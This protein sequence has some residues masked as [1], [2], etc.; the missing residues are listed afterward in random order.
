MSLRILHVED[1]PAD[2]DLTRRHL[3]RQAPDIELT[4]AATLAEARTCLQE[5][6]SFNAALV[7]LRLPD[8]SG[9]ELLNWIR[10]QSLPMAVVM[11]TGSGDQHAAVAALQ[12]GA[13]DYLTKDATSLERL[14]ATLRDAC[15]R[16]QESRIRRSHTLR[17]LYAEHNTADIDLTRRHLARF[18]PHIQLTVVPSATQVL[19]LLPE[20]ATAPA[21][22]DALLLDYRLPGL[23][24]LEVV[25]TLRAER[26]LD[27][28]VVIVSGQGSEEIAAKAIHLGVDDYIAKH[29]GYLHELPATLEKALRQV[30][31]A[32]E[33][34]RLQA[35]SARLAHVL[36][37]SPVIFYVL[38]LDQGFATPV[39]VSSNIQRLLDY[40]EEQALQ[41]EWW[42][43]HLHPDDRNAA[44]ARAGELSLTGQIAHNYR[45]LDGQG[46]TRWIRDE[47]RLTDRGEV[48]GAWRDISEVKLAEQLRETRIAMLDG[49]ASDRP[50]SAILEE[51]ANRLEGIHPD[52]LVSIQV[53]DSR[54][55]SL[56]TAAAPGLPAFFNDALEGLTPE[57]GL[58]ACGTAAATGEPVIVE[59]IRSHP[60][61][62]SF[63]DLAERADLRACWSIPFKD[64]S[65]AVLGIFNIHYRQP[66]TP[67]QE[68]LDLIGE[69]AR[70]AGL[71]VERSRAD[72]ILRQA[73]AV[74]ESAGE[75]VM[76]TDLQW[77]IVS[78]NSAF[79][80]ITGYSEAEVL[81]RNPSLL[82]SGRQDQSF[83]QA[84][85]NSIKETGVWKGELWDR[86]KNGELF[87]QLLT[88]STVYDSNGQPSNY[89][90]V[91]T[92]LSQIKNSEA[93]LEHLA[94]FDPLTKLPNRLLLQ[95]GLTHALLA[96]ERHQQRLAVLYIDLDRFKNINDSLGHPAGDELLEALAQRLLEQL[97]S[98]D[99]LGRLGGD[100]FLLILENLQRPEDAASIARELIESLDQ[101]FRLPSGHE[102]Y[103]GASIGISLFP[104]DG[105][106]C[107][108]LIQHADVAVYQ[109][110]EAG[111]NT[112]AFYTPAL[113]QIANERLDLEARLRVA[114][115]QREFLLHYQPQID[116]QTGGLVGCEALVRW[117]NPQQGLIAPS[118][119]IPL[120]E[121]TGLIVPLGEWVLRQACTQAKAWIDAGMSH[122]SIAVNLSAR[123]LQQP[124]IVARVAAI[125]AETGL[126][127]AALKL[128]LTESMIMGRGEEAVALLQRLK[129]LGL[130][131]SIDDFG[132]G[133]SSLA[134]LKRFPI[135][136]LK[137]DQGFVRDIPNDS[138]DNE[139]ATA[140]IG[141]AHG[142]RLSVMAEGVETEAQ[143][144]FLAKHGCNTYQGYLFSRPLPADEFTRLL[145]GNGK[146]PDKPAHPN[147]GN[148]KEKST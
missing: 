72:A 46:K 59:D 79:T 44:L 103:V 124:D 5:S 90:G 139:I 104:E 68:E 102:V 114:L 92:D 94:H 122:L 81:G 7:D 39:W 140:I 117:N 130:R 148:T 110:K 101:S 43:S 67:T 120:A 89:V 71:A 61:C 36:D 66:R 64:K 115:T 53:C 76:V 29:A 38:R 30:E 142:L 106:S 31:L 136:E 55:G 112:F 129:D 96:A 84:M 86:C 3:K 108:K 56:R 52:M 141:M 123:Q 99:T 100:E 21:D 60:Y 133:Y 41:P 40:S 2:A 116:I 146:T 95:S 75:G 14:A 25:K 27:I 63:V 16:F 22:F 88:I 19:R 87:P 134:Y 98:E 6:A 83:Y 119:F 17:V 1:N 144:D 131:L 15:K 26:G 12:A 107:T 132:T 18:A 58:G 20:T 135:D 137:I 51:I 78:V 82:S 42:S 118:R 93:R 35:T 125:L 109:A 65:G 77:N 32:R 54:D 145:N 10:Q 48:L 11:L 147:T 9:F 74:L 49:L 85:W 33:R 57:F 73:A 143:R 24:A 127:A 111:R 37:A 8:G 69:F 50:L 128:E 121:E 126:P 80:T 91:M 23:D 105:T 113:T 13:D 97:R 34:S 62:I 4:H 45:F 47:L 28:P 70:I 138:D